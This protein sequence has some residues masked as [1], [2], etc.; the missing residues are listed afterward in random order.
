MDNWRN[1]ILTFWAY[2]EQ[3]NNKKKNGK[4]KFKNLGYPLEFGNYSKYMC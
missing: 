3:I 2:E 4:I 1:L